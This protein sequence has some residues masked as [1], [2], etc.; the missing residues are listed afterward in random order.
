MKKKK[1]KQKFLS[2]YLF[3]SFD[4][5]YAVVDCMQGELFAHLFNCHHN[6][7]Q[8]SNNIISIR[9]T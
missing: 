4:N 9:E 7:R 8:R 1:L 3:S 5:E 6:N 2:V